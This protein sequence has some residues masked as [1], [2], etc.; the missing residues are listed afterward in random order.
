MWSATIDRSHN[1]TVSGLLDGS[2]T[3]AWNGTGSGTI[4]RSRHVDDGAER[5]YEIASTSEFIEVTIPYPRAADSWPLSGTI[6]TSLMMTRTSGND[7]QTVSK[8][9]AV[10]FNGTSEVP[11]TVDGETFILDLTQ[12]MSHGRHMGRNR[13]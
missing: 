5:R 6:S 4:S 8:E 12:R 10:E 9:V 2:G 1:L 13:P 11:V 7:A 3:V